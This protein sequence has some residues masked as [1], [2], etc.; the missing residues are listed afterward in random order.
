[1]PR[2]MTDSQPVEIL[3]P[4]EE[5]LVLTMEKISRALADI[6]RPIVAVALENELLAVGAEAWTEEVRGALQSL[7]H[8]KFQR[9]AA[10][11]SDADMVDSFKQALEDPLAPDEAE[12]NEQAVE[13]GMVLASAWIQFPRVGTRVPGHASIG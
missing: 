8:Q 10:E 13:V 11:L 3:A 7:L 4:V 12:I 5:P 6:A 9:D 1:M 2:T